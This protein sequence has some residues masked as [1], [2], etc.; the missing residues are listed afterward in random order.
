MKV[1]GNTI[2][3]T[4]LQKVEGSP[5]KRGPGRET[6]ESGPVDMHGVPLPKTKKRWYSGP[7]RISA[8]ILAETKSRFQTCRCEELGLEEGLH[9]DELVF[10]GS[11][12]TGET[13]DGRKLP[14]RRPMH[15]CQRLDT[16]R[17][18]HGR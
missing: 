6:T 2:D 11:G 1:R 5:P 13:M 18:R 16:I 12:C 8:E 4:L 3:R 9:V 14:G 17:R 15:V 7:T 10:L